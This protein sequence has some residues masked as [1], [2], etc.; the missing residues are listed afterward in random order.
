[1][2]TGE[3]RKGKIS[4]AIWGIVGVFLAADFWPFV[5]QSEMQKTVETVW[6]ADSEEQDK[7]VPQNSLEEKTIALTFDDG[8]IIGLNSGEI[9][10][11]FR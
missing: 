4:L 2:T 3:K 6:L 11:T 10:I 5:S 9:F 7:V 8:V 1:M